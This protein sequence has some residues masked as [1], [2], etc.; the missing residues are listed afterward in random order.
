LSQRLSKLTQDT[1]LDSETR[2][3]DVVND[4]HGTPNDEGNEISSSSPDQ[5]KIVDDENPVLS[6]TPVDETVPGSIQNCSILSDS[7]IDIFGDSSKLKRSLEEP[8][9]SSRDE[10]VPREE[11]ELLLGL[12]E[13]NPRLLSIQA[14]C[15]LENLQLIHLRQRSILQ[16][17]QLEELMKDQGWDLSQFGVSLLKGVVVLCAK[18]D[19]WKLR[20]IVDCEL[21]PHL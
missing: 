19:H 1:S 5:C 13:S 20:R 6:S 14:S 2:F 4:E 17:I 9:E 3:E 8:V 12:Q 18:L 21:L 10:I 16:L 15:C 7:S 11:I